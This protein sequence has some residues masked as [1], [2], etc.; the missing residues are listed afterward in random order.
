M[1]RV[2]CIIDVY[3]WAMHNRV[4]AFKKYL[5]PSDYVFDI[6][7]SSDLGSG[8][9]SHKKFNDYD[10]IYNLNWVL[11]KHIPDLMLRDDRKYK[12]VTTVCS[13][14]GRN[15]PED[16]KDIFSKYDSISTSNTFLFKEF[17]ELYGK[18]IMYAPFGVDAKF[19][20]MKKRLDGKSSKFGFVGKT[21]RSLKRYVD[22]L[23]STNRVGVSLDIASH[24]SNYTR[25]QMVNF[26]NNI[27]TIICYS[28]SEGTPNPILEAG[29]CGRAI[30]ST[31]VG[32][33]VEIVNRGY[34]LP[35]VTS[36]A[37]LVGQIKK[38]SSDK[39]LHYSC[40]AYMH[41]QIQKNW[42]WEHRVKSFEGLFR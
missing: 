41:Q 20:S 28:T 19:F 30:I 27:G 34:P 17:K 16:L 8:E 6:V 31:P 1:K 23:D 37:E 2:L 25:R 9:A 10:V 14:G 7:L 24:V 29:A 18:K 26:Y 13:H 33:V 5:S 3:N 11:H 4:L 38:L 35:A 15:G 12:L 40:G 39:S 22:I 42:T 21:N 32:N 36:K